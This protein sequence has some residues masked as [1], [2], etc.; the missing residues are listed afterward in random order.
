MA[1]RREVQVPSGSQAVGPS[2][3]DPGQPLQARFAAIGQLVSLEVGPQALDLVQL[4]GI[5]DHGI[6]E[7]PRDVVLQQGAPRFLAK[8]D[9]HLTSSVSQVVPAENVVI[10]LRTVRQMLARH[11]LKP[12]HCVRWMHP[13]DPKLSKRSR[14]RGGVA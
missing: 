6:E 9:P 7:G 1:K 8:L 12:W 13:R 10:S 4:G 3:C 2:L 14:I 5:G 11:H